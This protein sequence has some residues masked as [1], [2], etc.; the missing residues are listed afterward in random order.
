VVIEPDACASN[1]IASDALHVA[2]R[3]VAQVR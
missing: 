2:A 3:G 1:A